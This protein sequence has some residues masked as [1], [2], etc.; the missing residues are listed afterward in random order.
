LGVAT[1]F[2]PTGDVTISNAGVTAIGA[3]KVQTGMIANGAVDLTSK[4]TGNLPVGNL[5]GGSGA[6]ATTYW[7][8]NGTWSTPAGT[9]VST[10]SGG[11]TGLTPA[12]ATSGPITLGGTLAVANGGTGQFS[13]LV[14]GGVLYG[15]STTAAGV[16][17]IGTSG[18]VLTSGGAGIPTWKDVSA[19]AITSI[20]SQSQTAQTL[21]TG[22]AGTDFTINSAGGIHTF[23][24]PTAN[25]TNRGLLSP[26]DWTMFNGKENALLAGVASQYYRGDKTWQTLNTT[27]VPEG[28]NLY[29]TGPR[30]LGTLLTGFTSNLAPIDAT[31]T[32][33]GAFGNA[34]G[35]ID[36]LQSQ[37]SSLAASSHP[38]LTLL[39]PTSGLV[40]N[41]ATQKLSLNL[42]T[43]LAPGA[44]SAA[45][46]TKL[47][48]LVSNATHTGEVT[49][50]TYLTITDGAVV[51]NRLADGAVTTIKIADNSVTGAKI[52][53][54]SQANGDMMYYNGVDWVVLHPGSADNV[55]QSTGP[56]SAPTWQPGV[57]IM[58]DINV[59]DLGVASILPNKVTYGQI[60]NMGALQSLLGS[61]NTA[62]AVQEITLGTGLTMTGTTLKSSAVMGVT[63]SA[64]ISV[65]GGATP[66]VSITAASSGVDGYLRGVDWITFNNKQNAI[67]SGLTTDYYRG[68]KTFV[69][70]NT[71]V[72]LAT[73]TGF[74]A[75][76]NSTILP[77]DNVL[78]AFAKTQGQINVRPNVTLG[79]PNGLSIIAATQVLSLG[80]ASAQNTLA[81]T[82]EAP[83][84]MPGPDKTK[85]DNMTIVQSLPAAS[86]PW[87]LSQGYNASITAMPQGNIT[88]TMSNVPTGASGSLTVVTSAAIPGNART[89]TISGLPTIP[90]ANI[91]LAPA[92][93]NAA[94]VL[95]AGNGSTYNIY[96]WFYDGVNLYWTGVS[97]A[98]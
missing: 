85:L 62:T 82:T 20:N 70:F 50:D 46:K 90:S 74:A 37:I 40:L 19:I 10:F 96:T 47:D 43:Q 14:A 49:G 77:G 34:Q 2:L 5:N 29:F 8:G 38:A 13:P 93:R 24:I 65:A 7:T 98:N 81:S 51:T 88:I 17:P 28:A 69:D 54:G 23:N 68:D 6:L 59:T 83:G 63:G 25:G 16:T 32:V 36:D 64:P 42:A 76:A 26:G 67:T 72:R 11:L 44:M 39:A 73:L 58:G 86:G 45:D 87:D 9:G 3:L 78:G 60:Q 66:N 71:D 33:L 53:L 41:G 89:V 35:Q 21:Q 52:A 30:V 55:L 75:G 31:N 91:K 57:K 18:Q 56:G 80:L 1:A 97:G 27:A 12:I 79:T 48:N 94:R 4:V 92:I 84:A 95:I 61:S 22:S 15:S